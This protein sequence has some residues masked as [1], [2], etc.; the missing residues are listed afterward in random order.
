MSQNW[1]DDRKRLLTAIRD[2]GSAGRAEGED[3]DKLPKGFYPVPEHLRVLEPDTVLIVGPRGAG[4]TEIARVLTDARLASSVVKFAST[5]RLPKGPADWMKG[6]PLEREGFDPGG[7]VRF[8]AEGGDN[9]LVRMRELWFA[10]LVRVVRNKLDE[11]AQSSLQR[12]FALQGGAIRE[13]HE[14]FLECAEEPLLALDR[15]DGRLEDENAFI[16]VTYDELDT[17][18]GGNWRTTTGAIQG[19]VAFWAAYA[20]RWK[21][22]RAK[23]FLRTDLYDRFATAGGADLAK[24]AAN[25]VDLAWSD[26]DLYAM[27]LKRMANAS[28]EMEQYV[29]SVKSSKITWISDSALG[30]VPQLTTWQ[31]AR[32]V[33]ERMVGP[34][35]GANKKKGLVYRW[36]L[37]HVRD[38]QGRAL[39]RPFVRVVEEG[40]SIEL[41]EHASLRE[42]R[43]MAPS[44]IRRALDRVSDEHV[45][46]ARDEWPWL[47]T[48][49]SRLKNQLVPWDRERE[50]LK[51]LRDFGSADGTEK[52]PPFEDRDL[53]DYLVEVGILRERSDGRVDAPDLFLYGLGLRRKGGVRRT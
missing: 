18:G 51:L 40:A 31:D 43:L 16:F 30:Q 13:N 42:P 24:L 48:I 22:I 39:P 41:Q 21:R 8:L 53:L 6:F 26:A 49:K 17:L 4:K 19:L 44:S 12:L 5:L 47:D 37:D 45:A 2:V 10:Y 28:P 3:Q 25:R 46:H 32:P 38:G 35:M 1:N 15:L 14:A 27:L 29:K 34:Y 9:D 36:L 52:S 50:I 11:S 20:R 33:L 23:I 7:L